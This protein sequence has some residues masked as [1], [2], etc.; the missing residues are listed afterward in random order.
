MEFN[1][2]SF[3]SELYDYLM[4]TSHLFNLD[5]D[6]N[7]E[8]PLTQPPSAHSSITS[9]SCPGTPEMRRRQEEAMR[10][11]A[12]QVQKHSQVVGMLVPCEHQ[13]GK[14]NK[15]LYKYP[16]RTWRKD[17]LSWKNNFIIK[18]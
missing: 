5:V 16:I 11:L 14:V 13:G 17:S 2:S 9:G 7:R 1:Q 3:S 8:L 6:A 10:R 12:S 15:N 4:Q 18:N